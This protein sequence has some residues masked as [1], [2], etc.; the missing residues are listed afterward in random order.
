VTEKSSTISACPACGDLHAPNVT[1]TQDYQRLTL[2]QQEVA[3]VRR[4]IALRLGLGE[5][6]LRKVAALTGVSFTTVKR[7][8]DGEDIILS[9]YMALRDWASA[10]LIPQ[11]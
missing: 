6:S 2:G 5:V 3:A 9:N 1:C 8:V 11:K 4:V 7:F 10:G